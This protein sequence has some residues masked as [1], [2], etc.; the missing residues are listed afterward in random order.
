MPEPLKTEFATVDALE[1]QRGSRTEFVVDNG[2][3]ISVS[4]KIEAVTQ[5]QVA[6]EP[7]VIETV[8]QARAAILANYNDGV[9]FDYPEDC[10][11]WPDEAPD[12]VKFRG[13]LEAQLAEDRAYVNELKSRIAKKYGV[14]IGEEIQHLVFT[15]IGGND[16][17]LRSLA[18]L[19]NAYP[20]SKLKIHIALTPNELA[21]LPEEVTADNS[22]LIAISRSGKTQETAKTEEFAI[23][24]DKF[25]YGVAYANKGPVREIAE[26][27]G[28]MLE[29]LRPD[30][31]GRLMREKGLIVSLPLLLAGSDS[32][33]EENIGALHAI[34]QQYSPVGEDDAIF[35]MA[36]VVNA[37]IGTY[38]IPE[39]FLMTNSDVVGTSFRVPMQ[40]Y[41]ES[42]GGMG[43]GITGGFTAMRTPG[44]GI[45]PFAHAGIEGAF[46]AA[47]VHRLF[48]IFVFDTKIDLNDGLQR[49]VAN[50]QGH[51]G[52]TPSAFDLACSYANYVKMAT[53]LGTPHIAIMMDEGPTA[54]NISALEAV[55]TQ[56]TYAL[57]AMMGYN[58]G[59]NPQVADVRTTTSGLISAAAG[60]I[61][62]GLPVLAAMDDF[63]TR[64]IKG[65]V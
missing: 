37:M 36:A 65:Q 54:R 35:N 28:W 14:K 60:A 53:A 21:Q 19:I 10:P 22:L 2:L 55:M 18:M 43:N 45:L 50:N 1:A 8:D 62:S 42:V 49:A 40:Q 15:G 7:G 38:R 29:N 26:A 64:L 33:V 13:E 34:D 11:I 17:Y 30:I 25:K 3:R 23:Q 59:S 27:R 4:P 31:P 46:F 63:V 61:R 20:D 32:F 5:G 57:V 56:F 24:W 6:F 39:I 41:N 58:T 48:P 52:I 44:M 16:I 9:H 47:M 51:E 12:V